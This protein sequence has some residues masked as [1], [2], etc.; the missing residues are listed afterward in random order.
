MFLHAEK[1]KEF[2]ELSK[3]MEQK[4]RKM[5]EIRDLM[6]AKEDIAK[7]LKYFVDEARINEF[8]ERYATALSLRNIEEMKQILHEIQQLILQHW[9]DYVTGFDSFKPGGKFRFICHSTNTTNY[10][11]EFHTRF[12]STSLLTEEEYGTYQSGY[13]FIFPPQNIVGANSKDLYV[14]NSAEGTENLRYSSL[15]KLDTP[16]RLVDECKELLEENKRDNVIRPVYNEVVIDGFNPIGIFCLTDGSKELNSNY[17]NAV[18]LKEKFPNLKFVEIDTTYY[19]NNDLQETKRNL[20]SNILQKI[21][22]KDPN[23]STLSYREQDLDTEV[24]DDMIP[25]YEYF[26]NKFMEL[27]QKGNYSEDDIV[28]LFMHNKRLVHQYETKKFEQYDDDELKCILLS[29]YNLHISEILD[30]HLTLFGLDKTYYYLC[31]VKDR[32]R[33][34]NI[35]PGLETFLEI[36]GMAHLTDANIDSLKQCKSFKELNQGLLNIIRSNQLVQKQERNELLAQ[37]TDTRLKI[38]QYENELASKQEQRRE[39][40]SNQRIVDFESYYAL[41]SQ[42]LD[43]HENTKIYEKQL[44][45][46]YGENE[47][48]LQ[49]D[50]EEIKKEIERLKKHKILRAR[51]IRSKTSQQSEIEKHITLVHNDKSI[52]TD[53]INNADLAIANGER[54]FMDKT[55][56]SFKEFKG[57]LEHAKE[58]LEK[59]DVYQLGYEI[60]DIL[61]EIKK[62][63]EQLEELEIKLGSSEETESLSNEQIESLVTEGYEID[64]S[65]N[66]Q[67]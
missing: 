26:W 15:I 34:D 36:Y 32:K 8:E 18:I 30:G 55:G 41:T 51:A 3:D 49:R 27:K 59:T 20:F 64:S 16:E 61:W 29:N 43:Y 60:N 57:K 50:L 10:N 23:F 22:E 28:N 48:I 47:A 56:I 9:K 63:K 17:R 33:L 14:Y 38:E 40:D 46:Y 66:F 11:G 4:E 19:K 42:L 52:H 24:P 25:R 5:Y 6:A 13:G 62:L 1:L 39:Y 21:S 37:I 45:D 58:V 2:I 12:V 31:G 44:E 53:A 7:N 65:G 35:I 54:Q 67:R